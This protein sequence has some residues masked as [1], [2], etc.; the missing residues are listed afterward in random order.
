MVIGVVGWLF[1]SAACEATFHGIPFRAVFRRSEPG[2][3]AREIGVV[4]VVWLLVFVEVVSPCLGQS[5]LFL[6]PFF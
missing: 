6:V 3:V 1:E 4:S 2:H 5:S